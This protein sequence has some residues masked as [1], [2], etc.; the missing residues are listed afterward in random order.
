MPHAKAA[1]ETVPPP[2]PANAMTTP[3]RPRRKPSR[4]ARVAWSD[5]FAHLGLPE[6]GRDPFDPTPLLE[7]H[8]AALRRHL[9]PSAGPARPTIIDMIAPADQVYA[10]LLDQIE[11]QWPQ[12]VHPVEPPPPRTDA[13]SIAAAERAK[14]RR[15]VRVMSPLRERVERLLGTLPEEQLKA[16]LVMEELRLR[17]AG[18]FFRHAQP[19]Q[20]AN[21]LRELGFVQFRSWRNTGE[22]FT[23]RWYRPQDVP[24]RAYKPRRAAHVPPPTPGDCA[25]QSSQP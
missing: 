2:L 3:P 20:V 14:A 8:A 10:A 23:T 24:A 11:E 17:L 25:A 18:K 4:I 22:G 5:L 15:N 19:G 13:K 6:P 9:D 21:V 7:R 12:F 16:G 1:A